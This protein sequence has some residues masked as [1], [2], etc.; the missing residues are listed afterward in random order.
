MAQQVYYKLRE[1]LDGYSVGFPSTESGIE[2]KILEKLFTEEEAEMY[3]HV[4]MKREPLEEIAKRT[5]GDPGEVS[6]VLS[7]MSAKGLILLTRKDGAIRYSAVPYVVGIYEH[8]L[9]TM[10]KELAQLTEQYFQEAFGKKLSASVTPLRT[11]PVNKSL[12]HFWTVAPYE[13]VREIVRSS[14]RIAVADCMCRVHQGH[15]GKSCDKPLEVC[16]AFGVQA[17]YY[18]EKGLGRWIDKEEALRTVDECD[19]AGLVPQPFNAQ[20]PSGMCNCCGDCCDILRSIKM[21]PKP[22]ERVVTNYYA[23]VNHDLCE[24]CETCIDRCQMEA[25]EIGP[26]NVAQVNLDRC[27]GCGLC[28]TTCPEEAIQLKSKVPDQRR[29]PPAKGRD[30]M[31]EM[32]RVRAKSS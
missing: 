13:D 2:L 29:E 17:H 27:I 14:E 30:T 25:V 15:L 6:D 8:Q 22:S 21:H 20:E 3:L 28:V 10:D 18:V 9:K 24:A 26:D 19:E 23:E 32:A 31:M 12:D 4:T 11:I 1:Q 16:F 7:R 5:G